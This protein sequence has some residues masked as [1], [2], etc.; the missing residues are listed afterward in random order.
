VSRL[1]AA[2]EVLLAFALAHVAFRAFRRFTALGQ[3]EVRSE[4]TL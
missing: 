4:W 3:L 2:G 1:R